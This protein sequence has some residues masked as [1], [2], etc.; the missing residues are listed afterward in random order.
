MDRYESVTRIE[1]IGNESGRI[2]VVWRPKKLEA[3]LQLQDNGKT[4][5][6]FIKE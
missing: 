3:D 5:K 1:I 6:I 2:A 4:L